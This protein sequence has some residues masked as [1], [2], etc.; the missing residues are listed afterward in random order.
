M[1]STS[2][3]CLSRPQPILQHCCSSAREQS[4]S[5]RAAHSAAAPAWVACTPSTSAVRG[6]ISV[7]LQGEAVGPGSVLGSQTERQRR[8]SWRGSALQQRTAPRPVD[9]RQDDA[10]PQ[11]ALDQWYDTDIAGHQW[12]MTL[13]FYYVPVEV[14]HVEY[15]SGGGTRTTGVATRLQ[16]RS[17]GAGAAGMIGN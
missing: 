15:Y 1:V 8:R 16:P 13:R 2:V 10:W 14:S 6:V 3:G 11:P 7:W 5:P 17:Y 12:V 9:G 4:R